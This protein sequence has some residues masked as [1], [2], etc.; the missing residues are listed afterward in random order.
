MTRTLTPD[1]CVIGAGAGGF[2]FAAA[3]LSLG[4]SVVVVEKDR[5]G[6]SVVSG[7]APSRALASAAALAETMRGADAF[8]L[9]AVETRV[10]FEKLSA[11][12]RTVSETVTAN[13]SAGRLAALGAILINAEPRFKDRRGLIAGDVEIRARYFVIATGSSPLLPAIEG[14]DA[15]DHFTTDTIAG[16]VRRPDHL[17]VIGDTANGLELAQSYRRLSAAVTIVAAGTVLSGEDPEMAAVIL[18]RL[19]A[20]GVVF[21]QEAKVERVER[22][23]KAGIRVELWTEAGAAAIDGTHLLIAT[24]RVPN[25]AGLDLD[26]AGIRHGPDGILVSPRLATSNSRVYAIGEVAGAPPFAHVAE[27]HAERLVRSLLL[28]LP[29]TGNPAITP[30]VILT[31]PQL[32]HIGLTEAEAMKS[33]RGIRILRWPYAENLHAQAAHRTE[34]HIKVI[35]GAKGEILGVTIAGH[36]ASELIGLWTLAMAKGMSIGDIAGF[37]PAYPTLSEIGKRAAISYSTYTVRKSM[38]RKLLRFLGVSR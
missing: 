36:N 26:R 12:V 25:I 14:L 23:A 22:T 3:A 1:I 19:H 34:G 32:A 31:D 6:G 11:H 7:A 15:V 24:G 28:K 17:I 35:A 16:L 21:I 18:R 2:A 10:D 33:H 30:R 4:L 5:P 20:T 13:A 29:E 38:A 37:V 9:P 27:H 8:G